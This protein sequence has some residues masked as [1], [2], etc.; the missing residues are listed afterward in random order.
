MPSIVENKQRSL[1][2]VVRHSLSLTAAALLVTWTALY[3]RSDPA[4]HWGAF[5]GNAIADWAGVVVTVVATKYL[6]ER[7]AR[8]KP[9]AGSPLPERLWHVWHDHSLTMFLLVTGLGW[10][11][12]YM[13]LH[14][15]D[16]WGQVTGSLVS[17]WTQT[18]GMVVMSKRL[19]ERK[20]KDGR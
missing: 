17:E 8:A 6:Y 3:I 13:G 12:L 2:F 18:L 20:A 15:E 14:P 1:S 19:I 5:F 9:A 10:V 16:K 7:K 11:A 4:T